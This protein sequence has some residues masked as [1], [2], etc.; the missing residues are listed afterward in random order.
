MAAGRVDV[1]RRR[2]NYAYGCFKKEEEV[3]HYK[4]GIRDSKLSR[5][6]RGYPNTNGYQLLSDGNFFGTRQ[7]EAGV[8]D[9]P[10]VN[11]SEV[12]KHEDG[13][14]LPPE[15]KRKFSPIIWDLE[16]KVRISSKNRIIPTSSFSRIK[17][18]EG[19]AE[20][21]PTVVC[22]G[23]AA[24]NSVL[25]NQVEGLDHNSEKPFLGCGLV[26]TTVSMS[27][28]GLSAP[29]PQE[30]IGFD[31]LEQVHLEEE[32][33]VQVHSILASRW[34]SDSDT[35]RDVSTS[36]GDDTPERGLSSK[37]STPESGEFRR[38]SFGDRA[39]LSGYDE[40]G[41]GRSSK[42]EYPESEL[43]DDV[44]D[45]DKSPYEDSGVRQLQIEELAVPARRSMNMFHSCR[46]V[47]EF[48]KL[49]KINEGTYGIVYRARNKTTGEIVALKKVKMDVGRKEYHLE[50]G[51]PLSALREINILLSFNHP[52]IVN[53]KEVVMDDSDN[54]YMV[55]EF[56]EHDLKGLIESMKQPFSTSEVKCL[57]L[58]LLEGVK[59]L[60]DNWVLHRDLKTS[61]L[62]VNNQGELKICD[63]GMS[64]HYGSPLKPYTSL[65]VTLWYR[66]PELLLGMKKYSMAIDM[67]SLGCIMAELLAKKPLF[68]G[69]TEADQ[70]D[71]IFKTL[72]TP[73]EAIW[74][75]FSELPGA[76]AN[77]VKQP[78]NLLR[79]RFPATSFTGSPVLSESGFDLLNKLLTYDPEK[80]I[81]ADAALNHDWFHEVPLPKSKEFMPTFPPQHDRKRMNTNEE[82]RVLARRMQH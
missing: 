67:W 36:S 1:P 58:Q 20:E 46:S 38:E 26:G 69:K 51:F 17:S 35:P 37:S 78:F 5:V 77:F 9:A 21:V 62:L 79:K 52:S 22:D 41:I 61:N 8:K 29:L 68:N 47:F 76:K 72:G 24:K 49:N 4:N 64:R 28:V 15:K 2:D 30:E 82:K 11:N 14:Q 59:Y 19:S 45:F 60:H 71:K 10:C 13:V 70:I 50:H 39:R 55:M 63:F 66:A 54:V 6:H 53:V 56:M 27:P 80:R 18:P 34:A 74:P 81:T 16:E 40:L 25:E 65:V 23:G 57:M 44:M 32:E 12:S 3:V 33:L 75:G 43:E 31:D 73:T 42:D 7:G 48:E